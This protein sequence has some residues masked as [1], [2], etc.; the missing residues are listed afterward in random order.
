MNNVTPSRR[1][2]TARSDR[3]C[4]ASAMVRPTPVLSVLGAIVG[5]DMR[6]RAIC[7][8][9]ASTSI[10]LDMSRFVE[11]PPPS[12]GDGATAVGPAR[13]RRAASSELGRSLRVLA[14]REGVTLFMVLQAA[15]AV[16]LSRWSGQDEYF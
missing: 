4:H 14:R 5:S 15:L 10:R 9:I 13:D 3:L 16:V 7:F 11:P 1:A 6:R 8:V 12:A 2:R